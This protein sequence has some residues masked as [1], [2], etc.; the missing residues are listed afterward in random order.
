MNKPMNKLKVLLLILLIPIVSTAQNSFPA[1]FTST[2]RLTTYSYDTLQH[3]S[4]FY[5]T[6]LAKV[7]QSEFELGTDSILAPIQL[8]FMS[9]SLFQVIVQHNP[10]RF[11]QSPD[12]QIVGFFIMPTLMFLM[13][14]QDDTFMHEYMHQLVSWN[15]LFPH[16]E[17]TDMRMIH[18]LIGA[19]EGML[20]GSKGYIEFIKRNLQ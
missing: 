9:D 17:D 19:N 15:I 13:D 4:A 18:A 16:D 3:H 7:V 10:S 8:V 12:R 2:Q 20:I 5:Y 6:E 14:G 1:S 11:N